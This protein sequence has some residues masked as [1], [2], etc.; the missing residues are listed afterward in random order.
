MKL[1]FSARK[2]RSL[3]CEVV[4]EGLKYSIKTEQYPDQSQG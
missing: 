3:N 1:L 4:P 2:F